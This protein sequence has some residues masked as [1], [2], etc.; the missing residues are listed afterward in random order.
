MTFFLLLFFTTGIIIEVKFSFTMKNFSL[1]WNLPASVTDKNEVHILFPI[2]LLSR[3]NW[4]I[5]SRNI[6]R[7]KNW[8]V[9]W[10][11]KESF[12]PESGKLLAFRFQMTAKLG[13]RRA[14]SGRWRC[15]VLFYEEEKSGN[16]VWHGERHS[17]IKDSLPQCRILRIFRWPDRE[18]PYNERFKVPN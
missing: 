18:A 14:G 11:Y 6:P 1:V 13:I 15:T 7:T 5:E 2:V 16:S 9:N 4:K 8:T 12:F 3:K 17:R 10:C